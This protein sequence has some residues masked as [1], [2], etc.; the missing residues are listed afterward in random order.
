MSRTMRRVDFFVTDSVVPQPAKTIL[1]ILY[2][3]LVTIAGEHHYHRHHRVHLPR[4]PLFEIRRASSFFLPACRW[5]FDIPRL[6][7][8]PTER[9]PS[10]IAARMKKKRTKAMSRNL[11]YTKGSCIEI[12]VVNLLTLSL[13]PSNP[14][15]RCTLF[16]I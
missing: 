16:S 7:Q 2:C 12:S 9:S 1:I 6:L 11:L 3:I 5:S 13:S 4:S 14:W 10:Q 8:R 15:Q